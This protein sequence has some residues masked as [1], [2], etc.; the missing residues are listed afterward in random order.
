[1]KAIFSAI[2][3]YLRWLIIGVTF[4]FIGKTFKDNWQQIKEIRI[5][6]RGWLFLVIGLMITLLA[7][8]WSGWVWI[9]LLKMLRQSIAVRKALPIYLISNIAKYLPGNVGH[10]YLRIRRIS[11]AGCPLKIATVSVLLEPLL[12]AES[13]LLLGIF[14]YSFGWIKMTIERWQLSLQIIVSIIILAAIHPAIL[15][16]IIQ[17]LSRLKAN[18]Q[19]EKFYLKQYPWFPLLGEMGFLLLRATSFL[20]VWLAITPVSLKQIPILF[21]AFSF[22]WL[23]GLIVPGAPGGIGVFEATA[24]TLL[25]RQEFPTAII[26][27]TTAI[28]RVISILAEVI[29]AAIAWV[30]QQFNKEIEN[31]NFFRF[32]D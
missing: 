5:D 23:M 29:A 28:Y 32:W 19:S 27:V 18:P 25:N 14:S 1:M 22:A 12:M 4:L 31:D 3:P 7:H 30:F 21:S 20:I 10:F 16:P 11:Q 9:W 17:L 8:I 13:A 26:L 24:I 6:E 15:N 2:K